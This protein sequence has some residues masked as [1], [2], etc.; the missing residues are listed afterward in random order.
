MYKFTLWANENGRM[1]TTQKFS[2]RDK[3]EAKQLRRKRLIY[4]QKTT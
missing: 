1:K 3:A 2:K 4:L